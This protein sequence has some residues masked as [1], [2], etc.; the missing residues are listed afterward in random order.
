MEFLHLEDPILI[1]SLLLF[2]ILVIPYVFKKLKMPYIVGLILA[3]A[4]IGK[5]GLGFIANE[6]HIELFSTMG[7]LYIMF[8]ASLEIDLVDFKKNRSKSL[9]FGMAT[10]LIPMILGCWSSLYILKLD[11]SNSILLGTIFASHTLLTYSIITKYNIAKNKAVNIAIGGTIITNV[12]SLLV[13]AIL[14]SIRSSLNKG[15]PITFTFWID[16]LL[17]L[18]AF[19]GIVLYAF[20]KAASLFFKKE[21]DSISQYLFILSMLFLSAFLAKQAKVEAIIGAFVIGLALN[22]LIPKISP[23]KNRIDFIGNA[24]FIPIFIISV[25]MLVDFRVLFQD[26]M[27][28]FVAVVMIIVAT[29]TKYLAA[30]FTQLAIG[31]NKHER[32]IIFGMSTSHTAVALAAVMVGREA[33]MLNDSITNGTI[34]MILFS[35]TIASFATEKGASKVASSLSAIEIPIEEDMPEKILIPISHPGTVEELVSL[36]LILK[37]NLYQNNIYALNVIS[38]A[39][40][41]HEVEQRSKDL[42][43]KAKKV[44]AATDQTL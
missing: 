28:I 41:D 18:S 3:G 42:L 30:L 24:I 14:V 17:Y 12:L 15:V 37:N 36:G 19:A 44:V 35:C 33:G 25:G 26:T 10:F 23:L 34:M 21:S 4:V 13:L 2:V 43:E 39:D 6:D 16:L 29:S 31:Y 5:N 8:I 11:Q 7:L 38:S 40:V 20:P 1:F 9:I 27:T 22:P 32:S